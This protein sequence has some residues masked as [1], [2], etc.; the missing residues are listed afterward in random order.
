MM[1]N[2]KKKRTE[3]KDVEIGS[4]EMKPSDSNIFAIRFYD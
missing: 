3:K 4:S 1:K 2:R